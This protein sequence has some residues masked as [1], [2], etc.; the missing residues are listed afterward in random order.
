M[1]KKEGAITNVPKNITNVPKNIF[2]LTSFLLL[3]SKL[4]HIKDES[5][6]RWDSQAAAHGFAIFFFSF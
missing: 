3:S 1:N 2:C 6:V 5:L 4:I